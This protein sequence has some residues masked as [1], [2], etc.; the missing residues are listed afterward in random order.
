MQIA[1]T[2]RQVRR[3][4]QSFKSD[5]SR[6]LLS[7]FKTMSVLPIHRVSLEIQQKK[8]CDRS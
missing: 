3:G 7:Q 4:G 8:I 2:A 1:R 5:K 6:I